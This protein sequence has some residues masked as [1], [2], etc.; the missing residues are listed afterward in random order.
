MSSKLLEDMCTRTTYT[1]TSLN[2]AAAAA[3]DA[4]SGGPLNWSTDQPG[5]RE[6]DV[7]GRAPSYALSP[8]LQIIKSVTTYTYRFFTVYFHC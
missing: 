7:T 2:S 5:T 4:G 6:C 1:H 8:S 3:A